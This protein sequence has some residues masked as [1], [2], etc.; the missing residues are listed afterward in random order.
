MV[1]QSEPISDQ[2]RHCRGDSS[3]LRV[4]EGVPSSGLGQKTA[5]SV[6]SALGDN[7]YTVL[8]LVYAL[9]DPQQKPGFVERD[10][11]EKD[12]VRGFAAVLAREATRCGNPTRVSSHAFKDKNLSRR[13]C[14]RR[15]VE[16]RLPCRDRNV[17]GY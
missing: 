9:F 17:L 8:V 5:V 13:P 7:D 10:L 11:W 3:Q 6:S 1:F 16:R 4:P 2:S 14:H 12:D 15:Y